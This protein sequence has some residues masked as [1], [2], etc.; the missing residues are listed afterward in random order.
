MITRGELTLENYLDFWRFPFLLYT[1]V[2]VYKFAWISI[3]NFAYQKQIHKIH[4]NLFS[5]SHFSKF[6]STFSENDLNSYRIIP[7]AAEG[8]NFL[9]GTLI[10]GQK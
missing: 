9:W 10:F 7:A 3:A 5:S 4:E 1:L 8:E 2:H 6:P